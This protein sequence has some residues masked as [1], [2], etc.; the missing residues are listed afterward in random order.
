MFEFNLRDHYFLLQALDEIGRA[1]YPDTWVGSEPWATPRDDPKLIAE[2]KRKSA[3]KV[4]VAD[5]EVE[6]ARRDIRYAT[7]A[8]EKEAADQRF[9]S[10]NAE[11]MR[12][13][14]YYRHFPENFDRW[15]VSYEHHQRLEGAQQKLCEAL[16]S[17]DVPLVYQGNKEAPVTSWNEQSGFRIFVNLSTMRE[18]HWERKGPLVG[19]DSDSTITPDNPRRIPFRHAAFV[20]KDEFELWL[21]RQDW[22][23]KHLRQLGPDEQC[24]ILLKILAWNTP[25]DKKR[26]RQECKEL[27]LSTI[28]GLTG[29]QFR[30]A[31]RALAPDR[32]KEK[33]R[34]AEDAVLH[35]SS[36]MLS[37]EEWFS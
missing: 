11:F 8:D 33:S 20:R 2:E 21:Y 3:E 37:G 18:P 4:R 17:G 35:I 25:S 27:C 5:E 22:A 28:E 31:W 32:W 10:A 24:R 7:S 34:P 15:I 23:R 36:E 16:T 29:N 30:D 14:T 26:L 19:S 9:L 12:A 6:A 13:D 1:L